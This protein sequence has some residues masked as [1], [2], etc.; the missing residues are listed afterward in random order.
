MANSR[1]QAFLF[2]TRVLPVLWA[3]CSANSFVKPGAAPEYGVVFCLP[4]FSQ[5]VDTKI[6]AALMLS[7]ILQKFLH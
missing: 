3:C 7:D 5:S 2:R 1:P 4:V 6:T